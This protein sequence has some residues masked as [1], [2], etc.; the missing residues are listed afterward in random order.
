MARLW[1]LGNGQLGA[2]LTSAAESQDISITTVGIHSDEVLD[3]S[4]DDVVS[5]EVEHWPSTATT[6]QLS[7]HPNFK[8]PEALSLLA[9]RLEEK[10]LFDRLDL[11]TAPWRYVENDTSEKNL[12]HELGDRVVLK[13]REG[14]YDGK[15]QHWLRSADDD[16]I[17]E[18]WHQQTIAEQAIDFDEEVSLVGA[19]D[20]SGSLVFYPLTLNL[21][22]DGILLASIAPVARLAVLQS[23]A[24]DMLSSLMLELDYVGVM[25]MECFRI[26]DN[27]MIN[28]VAPRVHNSGHWTMTGAS[29]SQFDLHVSCVMGLPIEK[30]DVNQTHIMINLIGMPWDDCWQSVSN[31]TVYWYDKEVLPGRKLG[32]MNL[33]VNSSAELDDMLREIEPLLSERYVK[34]FAWLRQQFD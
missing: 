32:H 28:E 6:E 4:E 33:H 16:L 12:Y 2:M 5:A 22:Q 8:N 20:T 1:V 18:G 31:A 25:A 17:P 21:H 23:Q 13:R 9:D 27:L 34:M 11:A 19:R 15:G 24:E 3:L 10:R 30:P 14:G 7:H 26:G 29:L